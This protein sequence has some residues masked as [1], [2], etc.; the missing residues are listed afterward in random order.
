MSHQFLTILEC[1]RNIEISNILFDLEVI[2]KKVSYGYD[3]ACFSTS[4]R[5]LRPLDGP[6]KVTKKVQL[7]QS[8][9][10]LV[11]TILKKKIEVEIA[12]SF[13]V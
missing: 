5:I 3:L 12:H 11:A 9:R 1:L 2:L 8:K 7:S 6:L 10:F 4:R 13:N